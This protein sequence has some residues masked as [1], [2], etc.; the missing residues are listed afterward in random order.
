MV[1]NKIFGFYKNNNAFDLQLFMVTENYLLSIYCETNDIDNGR[2]IAK[3]IKHQYKKFEAAISPA[4]KFLLLF[5]MS[6][7]F[8]LMKDFKQSLYWIMKIMYSSINKKKSVY[9]SN[10]YYYAYFLYC[11]NH[12]ELQHFDLLQEQYT[13]IL[14][15]LGKIKE[16]NRFEQQLL[17][18][19]CQPGK[20]NQA[21]IIQEMLHTDFSTEKILQ[22]IN[23]Q[24][25]LQQ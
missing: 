6:L 3:N 11:I 25:W 2:L 21:E 13:S 4:H 16:V 24:D 15:T 9:L 22:F 5:N 18:Y 14:T 23:V 19:L 12:F 8:F 7:I 20:Q 10:I 17:A 1:K